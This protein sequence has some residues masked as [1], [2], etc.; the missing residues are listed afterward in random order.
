MTDPV[1]LTEGLQ[2]EQE[3]R[4]QANAPLRQ[5]VAVVDDLLANNQ[6]QLERLLDLYLSGDFGK[7]MLTERKTRLETTIGALGG[8]REGLIAQVEARTLTDDQLQDIK[9]FAARIAGGLE[10]VS[11]DLETK[12]AILEALDV[13]ATLTVEDG[14]QVAYVYCLSYGD[15]LSIEPTTSAR[16]A[17]R[18]PPPPAPA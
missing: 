7:E 14:E 9:D 16:C 3:E 6:R 5:R 4:E 2:V 15:V 18:Q 13:K 8:E 1:M 11:G 17:P 10:E 12:R